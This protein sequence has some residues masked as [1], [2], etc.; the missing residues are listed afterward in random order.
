MVQYDERGRVIPHYYGLNYRGYDLFQTYKRRKGNFVAIWKARNPYD[1]CDA[2]DD[3]ILE[4]PTF[5]CWNSLENCKKYIDRIF[6]VHGQSETEV[7]CSSKW[8]NGDF[9]EDSWFE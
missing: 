7:L 5:R 2:C 9:E 8:D 6:Y 1:D 4:C 3:L